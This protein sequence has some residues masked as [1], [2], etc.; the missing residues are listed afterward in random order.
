MRHIRNRGEVKVLT[1]AEEYFVDG[2]DERTN[3][4]YEFFGCYYHGCKNCFKTNRS[5][6]RNCHLDRTVQ[7]VY[8]A[9]LSKS[10]MLRWAG[11]TI[12]GKWECEFA[13]DKKTDPPIQEFLK[14]LE[15][16]PVSA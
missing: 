4:V 14:T 12:V 3:T 7:E 6:R 10:E 2:F 1:S 13:N 16:N 15:F 9:N 11:Y 5:V 8:E